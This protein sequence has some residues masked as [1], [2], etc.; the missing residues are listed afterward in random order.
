MYFRVKN[1]L[2]NNRHH[3]LKQLLSH[4]Q[5]TPRCIIIIFMQCQIKEWRFHKKKNTWI[6]QHKSAEGI[7]TAS[8]SVFGIAVAVMVV[9]LKK[10]FYK[11]YF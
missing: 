11:K 1:T 7:Q 6:E 9:V 8:M 3:T 10:L 4:S 5:T 2:K